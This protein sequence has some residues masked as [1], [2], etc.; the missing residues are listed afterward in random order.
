MGS[1]LSTELV[2]EINAFFKHLNCFGYLQCHIDVS[3]LLHNSDRDLFYKICTPGHYLHH[4]LPPPHPLG[5]LCSCGHHFQLP[6]YHSELSK[7]SFITR[8]L[9]NL[10]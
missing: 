10:V 8:A 6:E 4:L 7:K 3:N 5:H 1:F 2:G 9:Y